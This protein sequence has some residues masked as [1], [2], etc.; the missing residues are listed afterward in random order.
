MVYVDI[1]CCVTE[2]QL[3]SRQAHSSTAE[4][5]EVRLYEKYSDKN[6]CRSMQSVDVCFVTAHRDIRA[7]SRVFSTCVVRGPRQWSATQSTTL[8]SAIYW[9]FQLHRP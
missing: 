1:T 6:L 9:R 5:A 3:R 2:A 4:L 7:S 8:T